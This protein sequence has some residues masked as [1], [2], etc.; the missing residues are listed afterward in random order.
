MLI[1]QRNE[2]FGHLVRVMAAILYWA[3]S[4]LHYEL[5]R[6]LLTMRDASRTYAHY[7]SDTTQRQR[8]FHCGRFPV[9]LWKNQFGYA[10]AESTRMEKYAV[11][12]MILRG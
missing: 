7:G 2:K 10:G 1:D 4:A 8:T 11:L 12:G 5:L 6:I 3:K 9:G